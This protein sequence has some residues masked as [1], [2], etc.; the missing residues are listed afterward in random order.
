MRKELARKMKYEYGL[1]LTEKGGQLPVAAT[2]TLGR[3]I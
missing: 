2:E 3:E 1:S